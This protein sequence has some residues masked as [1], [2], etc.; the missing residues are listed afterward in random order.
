VR[1]CRLL[2]L[3]LLKGGTSV[4]QVP[5]AAMLAVSWSASAGMTVAFS[6]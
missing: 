6:S 3:Q 1:I 4:L 5:S 2:G